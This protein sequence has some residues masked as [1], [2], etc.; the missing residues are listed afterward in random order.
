MFVSLWLR[1]GNTSDLGVGKAVQIMSHIYEMPKNYPHLWF[2]RAAN[3]IQALKQEYQDTLEIVI[4]WLVAK[5]KSTN[6][7]W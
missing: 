4:A 6:T 2:P 5:M 7:E 1:L 3:R